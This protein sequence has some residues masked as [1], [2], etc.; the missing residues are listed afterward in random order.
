M[1]AIQAKPGLR[2][3]DVVEPSAEA[4]ARAAELIRKGKI[5][6]IPTETVYGLA[7]DAANEEAVQALYIAKGRPEEKP[8]V[9]QFGSV[10][11]ARKWAKFEGP[12]A[13]LAEAF[14]PGPLTLIVRK[15]SE[16]TL[17]SRITAGGDTIGIRIPDTE[18]ALAVLAA[19]GRPVAVTSANLSGE[20]GARS[21][22]DIA[23]SLKA[24]LALILDGGRA[25]IGVAST[26]VDTTRHS[27]RILRQGSLSATEIE[28]ALEP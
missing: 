4:I 1:T 12:A 7:V 5:V 20:P 2:K 17:A 9:V 24:H 28:K 3:P 6:A 25:P 14:W 10:A 16:A 21:V 23:P 18:T 13:R 8:F 19:V 26:V 27:L 22:A 11:A 15:P